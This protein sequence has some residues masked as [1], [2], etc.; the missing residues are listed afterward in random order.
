ME[1]EPE[2][3]GDAKMDIKRIEEGVHPPPQATQSRLGRLRLVA[4]LLLSILLLGRFCRYAFNAAP[5][6]SQTYERIGGAQPNV[7]KPNFIFILTDDQ[8]LHMDSTQYQP[9]I[10]RHFVEEGTFFSR[11]YCTISICC[12]SRVSLLTGKAAH[13]TNVT[14]VSLPYGGYPKFITEGWNDKYLPVWLQEAGY[15]TYYTGKLMNGHS[16]STYDKP[17]P[18]GWNGTNFLIDPGT[19]NPELKCEE[20]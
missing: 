8:D 15:N 5:Q 3:S 1:R 16:T 6:D 14:D 17:F 18:R 20:C 9:A 10:Q 13:N 19:I 4:M 11:H 2:S 7:K 12:P